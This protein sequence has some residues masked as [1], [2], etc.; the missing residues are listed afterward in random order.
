MEGLVL[1]ACEHEHVLARQVLGLVEL[2]AMFHAKKWHGKNH[3]GTNGFPTRGS[4]LALGGNARI[5]AGSADLLRD[6]EKL[7]CF[8]RKQKIIESCD[9]RFQL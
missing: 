2:T 3:S 4:E 8:D 5:E 6:A 1:L 7:T 9:S